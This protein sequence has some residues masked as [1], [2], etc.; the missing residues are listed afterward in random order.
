MRVEV[1]KGDAVRVVF[2]VRRRD[3]SFWD[4]GRQQW[5]VVEGRNE[6]GVG[7]SSRD[8]RLRGVFDVTVG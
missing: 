3:I 7:A 1:A 2:E 4:V 6:V 8:L 5:G